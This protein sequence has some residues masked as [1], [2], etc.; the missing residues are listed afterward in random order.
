MN[1]EILRA[2]WELLKRMPMGTATKEQWEAWEL[3]RKHF[4]EGE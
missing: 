3:L 2:M 4:E 1:E